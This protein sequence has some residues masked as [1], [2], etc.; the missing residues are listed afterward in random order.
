MIRFVTLH[1][2]NSCAH[3]FCHLQWFK[4]DFHFR[5]ILFNLLMGVINLP[6]WHNFFE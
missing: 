5:H 1:F 4:Y 6:T 3:V 2:V